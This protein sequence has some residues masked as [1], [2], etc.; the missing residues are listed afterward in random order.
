MISRDV[1]EAILIAKHMNG[2]KAGLSAAFF[3]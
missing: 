3:V 2:A 1:D